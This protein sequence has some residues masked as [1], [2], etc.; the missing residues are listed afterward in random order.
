[1]YPKPNNNNSFIHALFCHCTS[2]C[3]HIYPTHSSLRFTPEP[4]PQMTK[5]CSK[6]FVGER[7]DDWIKHEVHKWQHFDKHIPNC[8]KQSEVLLSKVGEIMF[9]GVN[10]CRNDTSW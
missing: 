1:M 9:V 8:E 5:S 6:L 3:W 2:P 4:L 10:D 7:I